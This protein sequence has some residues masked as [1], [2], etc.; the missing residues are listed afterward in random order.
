MLFT[1]IKNNHTVA[2]ASPAAEVRVQAG[3][4]TDCP[5]TWTV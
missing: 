2:L 4:H 5:V 1:T 3:V